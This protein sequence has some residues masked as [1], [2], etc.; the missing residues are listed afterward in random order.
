VIA[1]TGGGPNGAAIGPDGKVYIC[2]DRRLRMARDRRPTDPGNQP[3]D[4]SGGRIERVDLKT[5]KVKGAVYRV[6]RP[7]AVRT[8]RPRLRQER[9]VCVHRPRQRPRPAI[10]TGPHLLCEAG[11]IDDPRADLSDRCAER[12]RS[13]ARRERRST[14]WNVDR[15]L[16]A[17]DLPAPGQIRFGRASRSLPGGGRLLY[18]VPSFQLFDSLAVDSA[19]NVCVATIING[20]IT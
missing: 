1:E 2:N 7:S 16:W 6:R 13:L 14:R 19:G 3:K 18:N 4:Y 11:R 9:R 10:A 20:G 8:E 17:W 15:R 12:H 5:G